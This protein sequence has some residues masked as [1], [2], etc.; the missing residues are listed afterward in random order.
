MLA[1]LIKNNLDKQCRGL[2]EEG[3]VKNRQTVVFHL[4]QCRSPNQFIYYD[5]M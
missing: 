1:I 2:T 3:G 4:P 5:C